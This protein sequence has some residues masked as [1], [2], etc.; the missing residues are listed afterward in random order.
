MGG[1]PDRGTAP[2][3]VRL[4]R[5]S[6]CGGLRMG[7]TGCRLSASRNDEVVDEGGGISGDFGGGALGDVGCFLVGS[8]EALQGGS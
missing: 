2:A 5:G 6:L 7:R 4:L 3:A 1:G 8:V